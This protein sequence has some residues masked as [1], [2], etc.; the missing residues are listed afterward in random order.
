M[1]FILNMV[2]L[3]VCDTTSGFFCSNAARFYL[4]LL[5]AYLGVSVVMAFLPC[6]GFHHPV[7]CRAKTT[8]R[9]V[10]LTFDDGPHPAYTPA[11]LDILARRKCNATFFL[12]G[13]NIPGNEPLLVR[14]V[15]EGHIAGNHS[16][17]HSKWFDLFPARIMRAE[18][19]KTDA[20]IRDI[21]GRSPLLFRPP[22]GVV[23]PMV[24]R[25]LRNM[26]WTAVC[27][28]IRSFD[29][30]RGT[31]DAIT[32]RVIRKL[33][34]GSVI[35]LH[36][37]TAFTAHSLEKLIDEIE[38]NGFTIVPLDALLNLKAYA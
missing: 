11:I 12:T 4:L 15:E 38:N 26:H 14:M 8:Q 13:K 5:A 10:A 3:F 23:N 32:G 33:K 30:M 9:Q 16:Y 37:H 34:P 7:V 17:S 24:S 25:A 20:L 6:S 27:W 28:D 22:Y 36:D 1:L 18:L 29:T 2:N 21:T 19:H 31:P 35:L